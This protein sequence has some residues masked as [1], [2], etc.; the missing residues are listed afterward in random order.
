MGQVLGHCYGWGSKSTSNWNWGN[1]SLLSRAYE[2]QLPSVHKDH[3]SR[4]APASLSPPR[5][6]HWRSNRTGALRNGAGGTGRGDRGQPRGRLWVSLRHTRVPAA[7]TEGLEVLD[8]WHATLRREAGAAGKRP[9]LSAHGSRLRLRSAGG[10][11]SGGR[12][13]GDG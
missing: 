9:R 3:N 4:A 10:A 12:G 8:R 11:G 5:P 13:G 1:Y 7:L 6:G 2:P